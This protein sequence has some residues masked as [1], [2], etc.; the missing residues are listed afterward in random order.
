[1]SSARSVLDRAPVETAVQPPQLL[2][3]VCALGLEESRTDA[4]GDFLNSTRTWESCPIP[5]PRRVRRFL[6][7]LAPLS[8]GA[9]AV[10]L[11]AHGGRFPCQSLLCTTTTLGH[12]EFF[13]LVLSLLYLAGLAVLAGTSRGLTEVNT[14]QLAAIGVLAVTGT[15]ATSGVLAAMLT[16][17]ALLLSLACLFALFLVAIASFRPTTPNR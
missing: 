1:M 17:S 15:V 8:A 16:A 14:P 5:L 7:L 12:N 10:S 13:V 9:A 4:L 2:E 11:G 3:D 6:L